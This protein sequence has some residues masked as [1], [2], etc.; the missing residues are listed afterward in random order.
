MS[1]STKSLNHALETSVSDAKKSK[2]TCGS[3]GPP[4]VS[5]QGKSVSHCTVTRKVLFQSTF[6]EM[7]RSG[8]VEINYE[9]SINC[10][11]F[12]PDQYNCMPPLCQ[13]DEI[14]QN[15]IEGEAEIVLD[16]V[17]YSMETIRLFIQ[18]MSCW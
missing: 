1:S 4:K 18:K 17:C 15:V 6:P 8:K 5:Q 11:S 9:T 16:Y 12:D 14:L 13:I 7:I 2:R 3:P 10:T